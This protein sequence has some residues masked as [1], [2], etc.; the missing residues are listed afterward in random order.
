MASKLNRYKLKTKDQIQ[1]ALDSTLEKDARF[2]NIELQEIK[3]VQKV[4][5]GRGRPSKNTKYR[6]I[7]HITYD[8]IAQ[9]NQEEIDAD[10]TKDGF[11]PLVTNLGTEAKEVLRT[12]KN[13]P[14]LEKRFSTLKSVTEVAPIYLK[15]P[16]R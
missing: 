9:R 8:L 3:T 1:S 10:S 5:I 4:Q 2:F 12:Y 6:E 13:Q 14:Y 15:T 11:F 7:E 16:R